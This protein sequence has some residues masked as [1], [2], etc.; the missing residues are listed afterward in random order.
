M[1][2]YQPKTNAPVQIFAQDMIRNQ[3]VLS[4]TD[5]TIL[6]EKG[7]FF[8]DTLV[9]AAGETVDLADGEGNV[10]ATGVTGFVL[11]NNHLRCDYGI[12]ITGEVLFAKG[13]TIQGVLES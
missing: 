4:G 11:T 13:Y 2:I 6:V 10:I 9:L 3:K 5:P 1:A 12:I 7:I 8:L